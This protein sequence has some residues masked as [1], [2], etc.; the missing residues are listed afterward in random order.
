ML[1]SSDP[2]CDIIP[3]DCLH[4]CHMS[5]VA[6]GSW[7]RCTMGTLPFVTCIT[8]SVSL[9]LATLTL[10]GAPPMEAVDV[11]VSHALWTAS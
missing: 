8:F 3:R 7:D 4:I 2:N 1:S 11:P 6:P 10:G 5:G 9:F